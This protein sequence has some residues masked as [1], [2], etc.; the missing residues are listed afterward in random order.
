M[1]KKKVKRVSTEPWVF[2]LRLTPKSQ[3][4][5]R[6]LKWRTFSSRSLIFLLFIFLLLYYILLFYYFFF[7]ATVFGG[8]KT[9]AK[10]SSTPIQQN[11]AAIST[12]R[13]IFQS[14]YPDNWNLYIWIGLIIIRNFKQ[15]VCVYMCVYICS[16][17]V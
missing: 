12:Y 2:Y 7:L 3:Q 5:W 15:F 17:A 9:I 6:I 11:P 1:A 4:Y 14:N 16:I 13:T 8:H 10:I